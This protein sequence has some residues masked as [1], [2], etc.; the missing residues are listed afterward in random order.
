MVAGKCK[1][2]VLLDSDKGTA[3]LGG[4]KVEVFRGPRKA[5]MIQRGLKRK[6]VKNLTQRSLFSEEKKS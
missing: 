6:G 2:L 1:S 5:K 3:H 4:H